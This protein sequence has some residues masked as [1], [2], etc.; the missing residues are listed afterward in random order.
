MAIWDQIEP[1]RKIALLEDLEQLEEVDTLIDVFALFKILLADPDPRIR[2]ISLR[3]LGD[4][5]DP[6]LI[7][8]IINILE[9]DQDEVVR[10]NAASA[11]GQFI[12]LGEL[13]ELSQAKLH[14]VEAAL[15]NAFRSDKQSLVR[16][17][18]LES[19]GFSSL[20]EVEDLIGKACQ[21]DIADWQSTALFAMSRSA[22]DEWIPMILEKFDSPYPEVQ[23]EAIRAAGELESSEARSTIIELLEEGIEDDELRMTAIWALS[24]IGGEGIQRLF[25]KLLDD[26]VDED[27]IEFIEEA[28]ENLSLTQT[29]NPFGLFNIDTG[30]D[31]DLDLDKN[32]GDEDLD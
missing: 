30:E 17:R 10:S 13:E 6:S 8:P 14:R 32:F 19:L 22:N 23:K 5:E 7:Q 1:D 31:L 20:P 11:L 29:G 15:L 21:L 24:K 3:V 4:S 26:A 27:E 12:F 25:D 9:T 16:R 2:A 28:L 18:S